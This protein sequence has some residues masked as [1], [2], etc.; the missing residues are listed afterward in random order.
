MGIWHNKPPRGD[1]AKRGKDKASEPAK[2][3]APKMGGRK[4]ID[5]SPRVPTAGDRQTFE[6]PLRLV[7]EPEDSDVLALKRKKTERSEAGLGPEGLAAFLGA[8]TQMIGQ[9]KKNF[10]SKP[11]VYS[12]EEFEAALGFRPARPLAAKSIA[13][14]PIST[15][16]VESSFT[17]AFGSS[18]ESLVNVEQIL[19]EVAEGATSFPRSPEVLGEGLISGDGAAI[20][21]PKSNPGSPSA[22]RE[23]HGVQPQPM[24]TEVAEENKEVPPELPHETEEPPAGVAPSRTEANTAEAS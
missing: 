15:E 20:L 5:A 6:T 17:S 2:K 8:F 13:T 16:P 10:P 7:D 19:K 22:A 12:V 9:S 23:A 3:F 14:M 18:E 24:D 1:V 4:V 21:I 11:K